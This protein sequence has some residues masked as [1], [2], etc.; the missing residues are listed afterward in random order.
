MI[1]RGYVMKKKDNDFEAQVRVM[2]GF[3]GMAVLMMLV[4]LLF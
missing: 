1:T 2:V 4:S 3:I